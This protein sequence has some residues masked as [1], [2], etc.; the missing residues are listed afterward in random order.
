MGYAHS[1]LQFR[2][3]GAAMPSGRARPTSGGEAKPRL[4]LLVVDD[5]PVVGR[6]IAHI[7]DEC[8]YRARLA[9]NAPA[10]RG[11]Y[12]AEVPEIVLLD[13]SL[14]GGD[15]IELLRFLAEKNSRSIVF[16]VSGCDQ[17]ILESAQRLGEA[18]GLRMGGTLTKPVFVRDLDQA[19]IRARRQFQD[20][21]ADD[22]G[23]AG[24]AGA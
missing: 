2:R 20:G 11:Q 3:L 12:E 5:E 10:F 17:R 18:M 4:S 22:Q 14:P 1:P 6:M 16:I 13:L 24:C 23:S 15:G 8:G 7:A 21:D 19:I 9:I